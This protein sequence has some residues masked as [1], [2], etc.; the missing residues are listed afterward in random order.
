MG[1]TRTILKKEWGILME[2][3]VLVKVQ[4]MSC[5]GCERRLQDQLAK[6]PGIE[7]VTANAKNGTVEVIGSQ[8]DAMSITDEIE[9]LG[10]TVIG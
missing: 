3:K 8:L 10:F 9:A 5:K 7:L 6:L 1:D 2:N 4:G